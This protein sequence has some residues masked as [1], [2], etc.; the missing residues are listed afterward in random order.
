MLREI[1]DDDLCLSDIPDD[2]AP[3][4]P[5][6]MDFALTLNGYEAIP[7]AEARRQL[8]RNA[9]TLTEL[10]TALFLAQRA[11]RHRQEEA[12]PSGEQL[13]YIRALVAQIRSAVAARDATREPRADSAEGRPRAGVLCGGNGAWAFEGLAQ[14]LANALWVDVVQAPAT[15]NYVLAYDDWASL[16]GDAL[17]IPH[18][19][20][21]LAADK[22]LLARRLR[23]AWVPTPETR[24]CSDLGEAKALLEARG[25]KT[26][27][28]KY[29]TGTG[30]TGHRL[31]DAHTE[32]P[33]SWPLPLVMQEFVHLPRPEVFRTYCAGG[34]LFG[35]IARR[36]ADEN[37]RDP[38]VAHARGAEYV[39]VGDAPMEA[40]AAAR[41]A[42][43]VSGLMDSFGCADLLQR[44]SGEWLVLEVGTD[45]IYNHVDRELADPQLERALSQRIAQAF[46]RR[47][48]APP[49]GED[50]W[51]PRSEARA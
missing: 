16:R 15:F 4:D 17:F 2:D 38:W 50:P 11:W 14:Q 39:R 12:D 37:V 18:R 32:L 46:W 5:V 45:G 1:S 13:A 10:R 3:W 22:R 20:V 43:E 9:R 27:C 34:E 42:L 35:W 40:L 8:S 44:E 30:A 33:A 21:R 23:E 28:L 24:L 25:D 48:G 51:R 31:L 26:W 36:F 7:S 19:A 49:W 6:V 29:P 47:I 41:V